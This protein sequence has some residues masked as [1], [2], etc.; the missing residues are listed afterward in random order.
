MERY[1]NY[2]V[3][4]VWKDI[5]IIK[6]LRYGMEVSAVRDQAKLL[7]LVNNNAEMEQSHYPY[8]TVDTR[9]KNTHH[10]STNCTGTVFFF[11]FG[12]GLEEKR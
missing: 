3:P 1:N 12:F 10:Q 6:C 2:K 11:F 7:L 5:I 4:E 9:P 8:C